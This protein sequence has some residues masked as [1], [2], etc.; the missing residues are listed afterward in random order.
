MAKKEIASIETDLHFAIM[1]RSIADED[2]RKGVKRVRRREYEAALKR[3]TKR[4]G[5]SVYEMYIYLGIRNLALSR[6]SP[7]GW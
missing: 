3:V 2:T 4:L 1:A 7:K 5:M 6:S